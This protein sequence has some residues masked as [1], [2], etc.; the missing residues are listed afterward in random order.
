MIWLLLLLVIPVALLS[1]HW[2]ASPYT[3][4]EYRE[5]RIP[6]MKPPPIDWTLVRHIERDV[7][8]VAYHRL[9]GTYVPE[10]V[11]EGVSGHS[12]ELPRPGCPPDLTIKDLRD[13]PMSEYV[14][15][16]QEWTL[17]YE[18]RVDRHLYLSDDYAVRLWSDGILDLI[19]R[20]YGSNNGA[21]TEEA[22]PHVS[23]R[24]IIYLEAVP[25]REGLHD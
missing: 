25:Y 6:G 2:L 17:S 14:K 1:R 16:R 4:Q 5:G 12:S 7:H 21:R 13:M 22:T 20:R 18:Q 9:D 10:G 3:E 19:G 24:G 23:H 15:L 11:K 8:G